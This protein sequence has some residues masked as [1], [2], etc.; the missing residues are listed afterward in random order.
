[1][2]EEIIVCGKTYEVRWYDQMSDV[3]P[4][5]NEYQWGNTD[6]TRKVIRI[7]KAPSK[8]DRMEVLLHEVGHAIASEVRIFTKEASEESFVSSWATL[9][10]DTMVRNDLCSLRAVGGR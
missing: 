10:A 1:M 3:A 9:W 2:I 6:P 5:E 7:W 4:D 8:Q